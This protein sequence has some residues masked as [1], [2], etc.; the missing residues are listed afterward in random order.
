MNNEFKSIT[1]EEHIYTNDFKNNTYEWTKKLWS[2][3]NTNNRYMFWPEKYT[4]YYF[5]WNQDIVDYIQNIRK[6]NIPNIIVTFD[7]DIYMK[8]QR[9]GASAKYVHNNPNMTKDLWDKKKIYFKNKIKKAMDRYK[10]DINI[11]DVKIY[12]V[13]VTKQSIYE[14]DDDGYSFIEKDIREYNF[15]NTKY[16]EVPPIFLL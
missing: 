3:I 13:N 11:S 10:I 4:N 7:Y 9:F 14:S 8:S 12:N 1:K 5:E 15:V 16:P 6:I 2:Y